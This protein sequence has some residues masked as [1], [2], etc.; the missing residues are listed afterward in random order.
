MTQVR[1]ITVA[2]HTYERALA[3]RTL[4]ENEGIEVEL[5]N[6]NLETPCVSSGVRV[7]IKETDL[8]LAL[9]IIE[10]T[11]V[12]TSSRADHQE[13]N[14]LVVVPTDFSE[15]SLRAAKIAF[16]HAD[17]HN[18]E[19]M[20]LHSYV[21]PYIPGN[22]QLTDS[23]PHELSD[24]A[25]RDN[26]LNTAKTKMADFSNK[27]LAMMKTGELP[28]VKFSHKIVEGVP[29]DAIIDYAKI[30]PP[31]LVVMGTRSNARKERELIGSVTAEVLNGS[32]CCVLTIP[33]R[34]KVTATPKSILFFC[35]LDQADILAADTL[36]RLNKVSDSNVTIVYIPTKK[37]YG[38]RKRHLSAD[39]L[40][41]Y[42]RRNYPKF[43]FTYT[44]IDASSKAERDFLKLENQNKFDMI[45]VQNRKRNAWSR[46]FNPGLAQR[47]IFRTDVS[48][49]VIPV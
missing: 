40:L 3:L 21:N 34:G 30:N 20:L 49:L 35:N 24:S 29:E 43:N 15:L 22:M 39:A 23:L 7:R 46:L 9:R 11:D 14:H 19:I 6:V 17:K 25:N 4:L 47:I 42:C 16:V 44:S 32:R 12:F 1:L 26:L 27:L 10:N 48:T 41:D 36:F 2:I 45:V 33:E 38:E 37:R 5:N 13:S 18:A 31:L 8:P 28:V